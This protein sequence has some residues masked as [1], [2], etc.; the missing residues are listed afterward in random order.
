MKLTMAVACM[1]MMMAGTAWAGDAAFGTAEE[2]RAM[3]D[4]AVAALKADKA[5]ALESFNAGTDGFKDRDL[6]VSC[7][8]EGGKVT[9]HPDASLIGQDRTAMKD[10]DGKP[11]GKEVQEL[12]AE[13]KVAEVAYMYPRPGG[14][15]TAY[16]KVAYVT[17]VEN[18]ICLVG[19]YK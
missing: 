4:R 19:Y 1:A 18:Q 2:A 7:A 6:Y 12:A 16:A 10:V 17:K 8:E 11:F 14:D 3:L 13:G 9:A 15:K 5:K